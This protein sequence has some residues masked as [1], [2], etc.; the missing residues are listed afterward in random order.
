MKHLD[1]HLLRNLAISLAGVELNSQRSCDAVARGGGAFKEW[2]A[3]IV[4]DSFKYNSLLNQKVSH[5]EALLFIL[6]LR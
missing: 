6:S 3:W 1:E 4:H 5:W 2:V